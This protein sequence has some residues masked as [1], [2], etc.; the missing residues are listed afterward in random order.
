MGLTQKLGTIPLA[1]LT[2]ASNNVGIGGSPSGSYKLEVTG[3]AKVS[4]I[5]TLGSTI[6]NGTY[7]YTL[8]SATG[9]LALTSALGDYLPLAGGTL[10][11]DVTMSATSGVR[12][13][14]VQTGGVEGRITATSGAWYIGSQSSVP[15]VL[16]V[17]G[18]GFMS[19]STTGA[20]TFTTTQ[21]TGT[22][23][24]INVDAGSGTP[25]GLKIS[26]GIAAIGAGAKLIQVINSAGDNL[27]NVLKS[28]YVGIGVSPSYM[29]HV[30]GNLTQSQ[31]LFYNTLN[32]GTEANILLRLGSNCSNTNS[33]YLS[34]GIF[35]VADKF[36][37]YGNNNIVN[38][39]N[40]YGLLS[41]IKL[42]E[43]IVDAT[44]KLKDILKVRIVNY[45]LKTDPDVKQLGVIAQELEQIFPAL[46]DEHLDK[47]QEGNLL[48]T[49][50]K[51]VKMSIFV[52]MLI[53][54]I[55]EL[56]A[57]NQDLK[58]RLDKAGL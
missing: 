43:N 56:S 20:A 52:P 13:L 55:Q 49:K 28:G 30:Q 12:I 3:T 14:S 39:N 57:Q 24:T 42:K 29:F 21:T 58:S 54:A 25:T 45:N 50:T 40:S 7:T 23:L 48:G 10:T 34:G 16:T 11:G 36:Y 17:G 2:D 47:D 53:K 51:M 5:L 22:A 18:N 9:T 31:S 26:A 44:P 27:F 38:A 4:G 33:T 15:L 41:D 6:S 8:P 37:I 35:G 32:A 19:I 46:I 1:I